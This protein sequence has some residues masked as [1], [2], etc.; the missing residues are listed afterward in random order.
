MVRRY[1]DE[2]AGGNERDL[3]FDALRD[4]EVRI[5]IL[6]RSGEIG[7]RRSDTGP[8]LQTKR[9]TGRQTE[10]APHDHPRLTYGQGVATELYTRKENVAETRLALGRVFAA[11]HGS[12]RQWSGMS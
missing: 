5:E 3:R 12:L 10:H 2:M 1:D 7:L 6:L 4:R 9:G 8:E 11:Q